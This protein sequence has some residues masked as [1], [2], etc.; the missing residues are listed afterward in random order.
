MTYT[1]SRAFFLLMAGCT[2][3]TR[4]ET[5]LD[6]V[7]LTFDSGAKKTQGSRVREIRGKVTSSKAV[8]V[9][10]AFV[11]AVD[12][13]SYRALYTA[14][15]QS[16]G[17]FVLSAPETEVVISA[18]APGYEGGYV[19]AAAG[20]SRADV[21]LTLS[22]DKT[23]RF[24]GR[25]LTARREPLPRV[26][27][28]VAR[29]GLPPGRAYYSEADASG[30]FRIE[31][32]KEDSH[33]SSSF[34]VLVD[35]P[36]YLSDFAQP[37]YGFA[38]PSSNY[39]NLTLVAYSRPSIEKSTDNVT[40]G[41]LARFCHTLDDREAALRKIAASVEGARIIGLGEATHG[42]R[43][44][45]EWRARIVE[46]VAMA[47]RLTTMGLE[48]GWGETLRIDDYVRR[49]LGSAREAVGSLRYFPW[50]TQEFLELV[51]G[52]RAINVDREERDQIEFFG[53]EIDPPQEMARSL[54]ERL[55]KR[56]Q[57]LRPAL[58]AAVAAVRQWKDWSAFLHL[59]TSQRQEIRAGLAKAVRRI[60]GSKDA[61][62][63]GP[64]GRQLAVYT[65]SLIKMIL[66]GIEAEGN[67]F[68]KRDRL[69]AESQ[70]LFLDQ[71][72]KRRQIAVWAHD[73]HI[74]KSFMDGRLPTGSY[75]HKRL[76][77]NYVAVATLFYEGSFLATRDLSAGRIEYAAPAPRPH[78]IE[79]DLGEVAGKEG[80]FIDLREASN[81]TLAT[82]WMRV[83]RPLRV[84]GAFEISEHFPWPP[85]RLQDLWS[86]I[87][88]VRRSSP[89]RELESKATE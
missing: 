34:D 83:P 51:E 74:A 40:R 50:R 76:G 48:A 9:E 17:Y 25:V 33:W 58:E 70:L 23:R 71:M 16:N 60:Q 72:G 26:L 7:P 20:S 77:D 32:S 49:G 66:E 36:D 19:R 29:W 8:S 75:L 14:R 64:A 88:F 43:E 55:E 86:S 21:V 59:G 52:L 31:L 44:F 15:T 18:T 39:E 81:D 3:S 28:R 69:M 54:L 41:R 73:G 87:V 35:D 53:I 84:Y 65:L 2:A 5:K 89:S 42:T 68:L 45:A 78:F 6:K 46:K 63:K 57:R 24:I 47:G 56:D 85:V 82:E 38:Q 62:S 79:R 12:P 11:A 67:A 10:G 13:P 37:F 30:V 80:C 22:S 1:L 4:S 61:G 27:V